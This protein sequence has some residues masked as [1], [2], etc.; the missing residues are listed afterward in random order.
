[1]R[2][3]TRLL[4]TYTILIVLLVVILGIGFYTYS[5]RAFESSAR[6]SLNVI[7][8]KMSQQ[9]E[10]LIRPMDFVTTYLLS[11][12][13][14]MSSMASLASLDRRTTRNLLYI[15]EGWQTINGTLLSY[16]IMKNFYSVNVFNRVGDFLSSNFTTHAAVPNV[17][18]QIRRR[19]WIPRADEAHGRALIL[20]PSI[21]PWSQTAVVRVY[22]LARSVQGPRGGIGYI[23]VQNPYSDLERVFAVPDTASITVLAAMA[24]GDIFFTNRAL[25]P[26][27]ARSYVEPAHTEAP[28]TSMRRNPV[29]GQREIIARSSSGYTG[30]TVVLAQ[31]EKALLRPLAFTRNMTLLIAALII[32]VSFLYTLLS[33]RQL[34]LPLRQL[35]RTMEATELANLPDRV[36][37]DAAHD[38]VGALNRSFQRLRARL[39]EAIGREINAQ[40]LQVQAKL[41]SLQAQVNPHFLYNILTVL[42]N[43]GLEA[44]DDEIC[45]ICDGIASM[46][47]YSTSTAKRDATVGEEIQHVTTYLSLMK[48]RYEHRLE[49]TIDVNPSTLSMPIPK[50]V[51]QQIAENSIAHGYRALQTVMRISIRGQVRDGMWYVE[52]TDNGQGFEPSRLEELRREL[53]A[54]R[55][56]ALEQGIRSGFAIGG[57]G[58]ANTC[59]RLSLFYKGDFVFSLENVDDG[60]AR[61]TVGARMPSGEPHD[62]QGASG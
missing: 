36:T 11:N 8:Q 20:A 53:A 12:G 35:T 10:N 42:S 13:E 18:D 34:T 51:L 4:S 61:V 47:R 50:I 28:A 43:K 24:D 57:M 9:L 48:K 17:L 3:Q 27:V 39:N 16:S 54:A 2:F 52:T 26:E 38:E 58:L 1:M 5:A 55:H 60:G 46:L 33:S 15:N 45:E 7:A 40:S 23:E 21:D 22:G 37:L 30:I 59:A 25:S 49:F 32:M 19:A 14:F 6:T 62:A 29:T 44:G 41:D 56:E 31:D